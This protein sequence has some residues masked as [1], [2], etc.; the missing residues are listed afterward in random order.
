MH[1]AENKGKKLLLTGEG[2]MFGFVA[3]KIN[4]GFSNLASVSEKKKI[5]ENGLWDVDILW[6]KFL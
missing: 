6:F 4:H 2:W 5:D 1:F 3:I